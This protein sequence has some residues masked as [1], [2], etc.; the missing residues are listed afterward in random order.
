MMIFFIEVKLEQPE[1]IFD[2]SVTFSVFIDIISKER[3]EHPENILDIF[4]A[5]EKS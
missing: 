2:I 5:F 3:E 1:K 4:K